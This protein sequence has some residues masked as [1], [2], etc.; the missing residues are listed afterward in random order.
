MINVLIM[1][2]VE[3][4]TKSLLSYYDFPLMW[5]YETNHIS[6]VLMT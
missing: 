1:H 6:I 4:V 2:S 3:F 5:R